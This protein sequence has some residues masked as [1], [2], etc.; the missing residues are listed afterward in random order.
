MLKLILNT[1][2]LKT[3]LSI[4]SSSR[5]HSAKGSRINSNLSWFIFWITTE[6]RRSSRRRLRRTLQLLPRAIPSDLAPVTHQ[7]AHQRIHDQE[8]RQDDN[9]TDE[10]V[11]EAFLGV[12]QC[13]RVALGNQLDPSHQGHNRED[14]EGDSQEPFDDGVEENDELAG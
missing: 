3:D 7:V 2:C 14:E 13:S 5:L 6:K 9:E 1:S 8:G 10:G 12:S 11:G 4:C